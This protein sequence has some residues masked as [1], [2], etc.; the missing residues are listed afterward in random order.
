MPCAQ[1]HVVIE[2]FQ[3]VGAHVQYDRQHPAR[4]DASGRRVDG[5]LADGDLDAADALVADA[6]NALGV[7][8]HQ[9]VDVIRPET[10][11]PQSGFDVLRM[12]HRQVDTSGAAE[13]LAEP[14]DRQPHR[15]GV[16]HRQHLGDVLG[17][18]PVEEHLVAIAKVGQLHP[19]PQIVGLFRVLGVDPAHWPSKVVTSVGRRPVRLRST[20]SYG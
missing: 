11:V 19:L 12:I 17:E 5:E 16:H 1:V 15:R 4:V 3:I 20:R 13:F 2:Q 18:Q 6:Q 8:G 7:G 10:G 14:L 9:Q